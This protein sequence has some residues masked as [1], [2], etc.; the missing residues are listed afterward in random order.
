MG[1][2]AAP[3]IE[4]DKEYLTFKAL[5]SCQF[6]HT[7][8]DIDYS[9]DG[10]TTWVTLSADTAS[11]V[12]AAGNL[13]KFKGTI[14]PSS[15]GS[16]TFSSTG[17]Y[18]AM[19]NPIS[20]IYGD[21]FVGVVDLSGKT[22]P[23]RR[24]FYSS[25]NIASSKN[26]VLVAEK[27]ST[28]AYN[29][30]FYGCSAM[31]KTVSIIAATTIGQQ[32]CDS[33][34]RN[35]T[36]LSKAPELTATT[37]ANYCYRN[38]FAG[39]TGLTTIQR[40]LPATTLASNCYNGMFLG[41]TGITTAPELPATTLVSNCYRLM[42]DGCRNL[43]YI[44]AMFT[45]TPGSSYTYLWVRNVKSSGT[46]VKSSSATWEVSGNDGIPSGWTIQTASE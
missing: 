19:G 4:W 39:C 46:F 22:A 33:M 16:G 36:S 37:I 8:F 41:C 38:M 7:L 32:C 28:S 26:L 40:S 43:S 23:F 3:P 42:F 44:K 11:P 12:V 21:N 34:Y 20:L 5:D 29:E 6:T 35:C 18:E 17:R 2:V 13:V 27:A 15:S 25:D 31:I 30:M 1:G 10:G 24:M 9:L 45:T 14:T